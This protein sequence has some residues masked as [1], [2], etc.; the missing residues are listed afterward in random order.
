MDP[1]DPSGTAPRPRSRPGSVTWHVQDVAIDLQLRTPHVV[2]LRIGEGSAG[3]RSIPILTDPVVVDIAG[4]EIGAEA[5][6]CSSG[7][8]LGAQHGPQQRGEVTADADQA[9]LGRSRGGQRS[10]VHG[11]D[12]INHPFH[13][14]NMVFACPLFGDMALQA[15]A[16]YRCS[17]R[18]CTTLVRAAMSFGNSSKS[19]A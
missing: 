12:V 3:L 14:A 16:I 6:T 4:I 13:R 8:T 19:C 15:A 17:V 11:E 18:P 9:L 5:T 1:P 2:E 7:K 10:R